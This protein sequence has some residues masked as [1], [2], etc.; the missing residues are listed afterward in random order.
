MLT[1]SDVN[2]PLMVFQWAP[3][4]TQKVE[5]SVHKSRAP[6]CMFTLPSSPFTASGRAL[7]TNS[8][9]VSVHVCLHLCPS[10]VSEASLPDIV[11]AMMDDG[12]SEV[13]GVG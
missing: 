2:Q 9:Q 11:I 4:T 10:C 13:C 8:E 5:R 6:V 3:L 1:A 12:K 7:Q